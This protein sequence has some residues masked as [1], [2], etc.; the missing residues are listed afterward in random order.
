LEIAEVLGCNPGTVKSR[1]HYARAAL[2]C[3]IKEQSQ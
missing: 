3:W 2:G 1:L